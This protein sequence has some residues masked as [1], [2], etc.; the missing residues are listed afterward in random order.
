MP[1]AEGPIGICAMYLGP[2]GPG[3]SAKQSIKKQSAAIPL[4]PNS[5]L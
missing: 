4:K 2:L 1:V 5:S 3:T